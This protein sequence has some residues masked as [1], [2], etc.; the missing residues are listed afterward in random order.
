MVPAYVGANGV[1]PLFYQARFQVR[2]IV[3]AFEGE[4]RSPLNVAREMRRM[5]GSHTHFIQSAM[6]K[7]DWKKGKMM[8]RGH[9][10]A[11]AWRRHRHIQHEGCALFA[12][13]RSPRD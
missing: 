10:R 9:G 4:R 2:T 11:T 13:W 12:E 6:I 7:H 1:R 3:A 8:R 5:N